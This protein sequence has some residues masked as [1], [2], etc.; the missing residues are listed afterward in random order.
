MHWIVASLSLVG[1]VAAH[2]AVT[3]PVT[4][5]VSRVPS[6]QKSNV[7]NRFIDWTSTVGCMRGWANDLS[8]RGYQ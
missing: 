2:G 4:R 7:S 1:Y 6:L 5:G 3:S 8:R